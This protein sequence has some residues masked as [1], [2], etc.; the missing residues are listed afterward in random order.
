MNN[1][2]RSFSPIP[3]NYFKTF[4]LTYATTIQNVINMFQIGNLYEATHKRN[5]FKENSK[6]VPGYFSMS[7]G[8]IHV[9]TSVKF[10]TM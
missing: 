9:I 6:L 2:Y 1:I 10:K 8:F 7:H 4:L 3:T 5:K